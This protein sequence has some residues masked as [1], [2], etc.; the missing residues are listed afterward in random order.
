MKKYL[1][2]IFLF[3][4]IFLCSCKKDDKEKEIDWSTKTIESVV[5][6]QESIDKVYEYDEFDVSMILLDITYTDG[7]SRSIPT[8]PDMY[9]ESSL[10]KLEK[11]GSPK[12]LLFYEDPYSHEFYNFNIIIKLVDSSLLDIY[13]NV[14]HEYN[15]VIKAIRDKTKNSINF[16]CEDSDTGVNSF[17]F[18]YKFDQSIM[19][20]SNFRQN[21]N[22]SG[23]FEYTIKDGMLIV[24]IILRK[25]I[26][27][28]TTLFT[29]DYTGD[30]RTSKLG[31]NLDFDNLCYL[32][33]ET[34]V[35][36]LKTLY[37]A[38]VK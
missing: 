26:T 4:S 20:I 15:V 19:Q 5:I 6:N 10:K 34:E 11:P 21:P 2:F 16:I 29:V 36:K 12:V 1:I 14:P 25:A 38:S 28:E 35:I 32:V 27:E 23:M 33:N 13:L 37:H 24:T 17:Q 3:L 7:T 31:I 9:D 8:T 22:L 30:F 18:A